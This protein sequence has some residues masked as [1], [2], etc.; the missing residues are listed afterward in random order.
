[1]T[2]ESEKRVVA[3][4]WHL[5]EVEELDTATVR[6]VLEQ[7]AVSDSCE[8]FAYREAELDALWSIADI[9]AQAGRPGAAHAVDLLW[10]AH[11]S[12]GNGEVERALNALERLIDHLDQHRGAISVLHQVE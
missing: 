2:L 7:L 6:L 11:D 10:E 5:V 12:V 3:D 8:H 9:A 4:P 1:M